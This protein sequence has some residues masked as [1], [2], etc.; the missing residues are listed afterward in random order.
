[1]VGTRSLSR[2]EAAVSLPSA[3]GDV[4][5]RVLEFPAS[6]HGETPPRSTASDPLSRWVLAVAGGCALLVSFSQAPGRIVSDTK[7]PLVM[8][9]R[10]FTST[11]LHLWD[12]NLWSGSIQT[13]SF[14]YIFPM[15]AFYGLGHLLHVPVWCTE[16]VW[17]ALLLT[18]GFWGVVR[19]AEALHIGNRRGRVIGAIAYTIAPIVVT[20]AAVTAALLAVVLLPWVLIP[21]VRGS[22]EGSPRRAA[23]ASGLAVALMGGVNST[24]VVATLPLGAVWLLTR[25]RGA[26]R[27]A[28]IGWWI[29]ALVMACFWW[30]AALAVE[31]HYG[32]NYLPYT[33]TASMTTSTASLFESLRG[34]SYWIDYFNIRGPLVP[35]AW[36]LVSSVPAIAGTTAVAAL[37]LAGLTRR[38]PE[39]LF[40]VSALAVGVVVIAAGYAGPLG[41]PES[42]AVQHLL[43]G[44]LA[45][46]R[47]VSKFSPDVALPLALGLAN[48]TSEG[49]HLRRWRRDR[50]SLSLHSAKVL[51]AVVAVAAIVLAA[52]PFW[53]AQLY[54]TGTFASIPGYWS[55]AAHWLDTHQ[56][57]GTALLAPAA[58]SGEYT[59]GRPLDEPLSVL[60][61]SSVSV[62]SLIPFGSNGNDQVMDGLEASLD[63]GVPEPQMGAYLARAGY[64]YVVVRN[65]LDLAQTG[66]PPPAQVRQVLGATSGL[67]LVAS[68]GPVVSRYQFNPSRLAVYD[69]NDANGLRSVQIY[70]VVPDSSIVRTYP[71]ADPVIVSGSPSSLVSLLNAG[72]LEGRAAF[73]S[74]D[75]G[76]RA[77]TAAPAATWAETD[78]NQRRDVGFGAVRNNASYVL[79]PN[80]RSSI[81]QPGVPQNLAVVSGTSHQ[82][83]ARPLGAASVSASSFSSTPLALDPAQGPAAAFDDDQ[84]TSWVANATDRSVGQWAQLDFGRP[85]MLHT[86]TVRPLADGAQRPTVQAVRISTADG[87]VVRSI[88][89]GSNTLTVPR[90]PSSWLRVTL[91][92][93]KPARERPIGGYPLGAGLTSITI[94]GVHYVPALR[95][96]SDEASSL[97]GSGHDFALAFSAPVTAPN[98]EL[99]QANDDDPLMVRR[100]D[101]PAATTLTVLGEATP[102]PGPALNALLPQVT[103]SVSVTSS[104]V[105]GSLPRYSATNL[106]TGSHSPWIAAQGDSRP[107]LTFRWSGQRSVSSVTITPTAQAARPTEI[108]ITSPAGRALVAV[109]AHGGTVSFPPMNTDSLTIRFV[110]VARTIGSVPATGTRI[111]LPVGVAQLSIPSLGSVSGTTP[112]TNR[113][114]NLPCGKGPD[115]RLDGAVI[116]T[117]VV[118]T[119]SDLE[120]LSQMGLF[121]CSSAAVSPGNHVIEA[122]RLGGAFKVTSLQG[123]PS[124]T[125]TPTGRPVRI[126]GA[127]TTDHRS[128]HVGAGSA[129]Y[130]AVAQ[131]Y[132]TAWHATL[133]GRPLTAVRLDGWQQG[134]KIPAGQGGTVVMTMPADSWYRLALL[135]GAVL[136][137]LLAAFALIRRGKSDQAPTG[138]GRHVPAVVLGVLSLA[139]LIVVCGPLALVVLPLWFVGRRWGRTPLAFIAAGALLGAGIA[140]AAGAGTPPQT[141]FHAFGW[142]TQGAF[143]WPAQVGAAI[144]LGAV[145]A[146]LIARTGDHE[147]ETEPSPSRRRRPVRVV[148]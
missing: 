84:A 111:V 76:S 2:A 75:V 143:G 5:G 109:P 128:V 125:A 20:W 135:L 28:L 36:T 71:A 4:P 58:G 44:P 62:R 59:W 123:V 12:P 115:L 101:A 129:A 106:V 146:S 68:F 94:P 79:G 54:P 32:Y 37:G 56:D 83:V 104:S 119:V 35:G 99:G 81:A 74:G 112:S 9:P 61:S 69:P 42:A 122:G 131:N 14:G 13:L 64:D 38:I 29:V 65:D 55:Q 52:A 91:T 92:T 113:P 120:N 141:T 147:G 63:R 33:E 60:A 90:G 17:L 98:F 6:E 26:R 130:L 11:A 124:S 7:L 118:G 51:V 102:N 116:R 50:S 103:S 93:V 57:H 82:A 27:R 121:A 148:G 70:R 80:Q 19:L 1:M 126:V 139:V 15:G 88:H 48:L 31:S 89:R 100:F 144:A 72:V 140:A 22:T 77:A 67:K 41:G 16:R 142:P 39:R 87:S 86:I 134:W 105:L 108:R 96:P 138:P 49:L 110:K 114:V 30:A 24:V 45:A 117:K 97:T 95:V 40:L 53:R 47:N 46:L 25:P 23:F 107:S 66:A 133:D 3:D 85:V 18:T 10:A 34:A 43:G 137:V 127:W 8:A 145:F 73:L 132:N 136:L 78:G 21:L